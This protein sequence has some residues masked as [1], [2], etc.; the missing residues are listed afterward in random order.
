[1]N[2]NPNDKNSSKNF[3]DPKVTADDLFITDDGETFEQIEDYDAYNSLGNPYPELWD[4][5]CP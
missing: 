5:G 2:Q 3:L 4:E 1:M